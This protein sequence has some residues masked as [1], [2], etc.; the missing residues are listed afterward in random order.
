MTHIREACV[1]CIAALVTW[2]AYYAG[3][4]SGWLYV[5]SDD[6]DNVVAVVSGCWLASTA[7]FQLV[8]GALQ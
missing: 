1:V 4:E 7:L 3:S 8:K 2:M 6:L 5:Y